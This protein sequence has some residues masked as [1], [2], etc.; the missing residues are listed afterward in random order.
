MNKEEVNAFLAIVRCGTITNA[1]TT[2]YVSQSSL[3]QRLANLEKK[4][5]TKLITRG[6]GKATIRLTEAGHEFL[7]I[8]DEW[9]KLVQETE[10]LKYVS[11]RQ[12]LRI[13]SVDSVSSFI[14]YP[15]FETIMRKWPQTRLR[16][17]TH[18]SHELYALMEQ[19]KIDIG[20][21]LQQRATYS[22]D[23]EPLFSEEMF[24]IMR[25]D[26]KLYT[27]ESMIDNQQLNPEKELYINWSPDYQERHNQWWQTNATSG[28]Q[29]DTAHH[30][31]QLL[32]GNYWAIVPLSIVQALAKDIQ[33]HV[34]RLTDPPPPRTCYM[35][36]R[37]SQHVKFIQLFKQVKEGN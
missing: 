32:H 14:L 20:F 16:I 13:G 17:Q 26:E 24:V 18:Q 11:N 28:I 35:L 30:L 3:S 25:V 21:V 23:I 36:S 2:L 5:D 19:R 31:K 8:A 12:E 34:Y 1:A 29:L 7:R 10:E 37:S 15:I 33:L 27:K 6:K 22:F 9:E 4:L